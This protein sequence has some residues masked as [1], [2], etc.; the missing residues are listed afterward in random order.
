[1]KR[2][3]LN[4]DVCVVQVWA[5]GWRNLKECSDGMEGDGCLWLSGGGGDSLHC[6]NFFWS[7]GGAEVSVNGGRACDDRLAASGS[8]LLLGELFL[9]TSRRLDKNC[10]LKFWPPFCVLLLVHSRSHG[11]MY[12]L[13][14]LG[15]LNMWSG[16]MH[17][18]MPPFMLEECVCVWI[19]AVFITLFIA[20]DGRV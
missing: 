9:P 14:L 11:A 4:A 5:N 15:W 3:L 18:A 8:V 20:L 19:T 13:P 17:A 2:G 1:M 10:L 6:L 7:V 16:F 12:I